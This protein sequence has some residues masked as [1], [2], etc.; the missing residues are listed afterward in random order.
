MGSSVSSESI[1]IAWDAPPTDSQN[2]MIRNYTVNV[3]E[4]ETGMETVHFSLTT[5]ITLFSLHPF[6]T[7]EITI[8]AVTVAQGPLSSPI[9]VQTD[10]DGK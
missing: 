7:Y 3:T 6:Y 4:I 2:G 5:E 8:A 1:L 9:T 10:S